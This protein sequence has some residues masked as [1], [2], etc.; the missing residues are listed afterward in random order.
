VLDLGCGRGAVTALL[1]DAVAPDG[2]VTALD[3]SGAMVEHTRAL[4]P[5][6]HVVKGDAAR[7][8]LGGATYDALT[9]SLVLFFLPEPV[10]VAARWL[11][12]L[13]PGGRLG[14]T[15]FGAQNDL[16]RN[17]DALFKPYL[18]P[19]LR[20]PRVVG[21]D[22]P[23]AT[24]ERLEALL[25][26]AGAT[27]VETRVEELTFRVAGPEQWLAFSLGTGQRAIWGA[28]PPEERVRIYDEAAEM[29]RDS[30]DVDGTSELGQRV[31]YTVARRD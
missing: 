22:S 2:T 27:S 11:D 5:S 31:R 19:Q 23:F 29:L 1:P 25:R 24:D 30:R 18:P 15:T 17:V 28:V 4:V 9:A 12:L 6:A 3:L 14:L 21:P 10:A 26:E 7:P 16:W 20:D 13:A 8:D